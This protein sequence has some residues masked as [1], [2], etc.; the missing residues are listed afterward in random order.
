MA[1][2]FGAQFVLTSLSDLVKKVTD[3]KNRRSLAPSLTQFAK[4]ANIIGR[5]YIEETV[6]HDDIAVPLMGVLNQM[7]V[8]Y[9]LTALHLDTAVAGGR[10]VREIIGK[11][12]SEGYHDAANIILNHFGKDNLDK[13]LSSME[14]SVTKLEEDSQRLVCGRL[15]ELDMYGHVDVS[16]SEITETTDPGSTKLTK[17]NELTYKYDKDGNYGLDSGSRGKKEETTKEKTIT[18]AKTSTGKV[19]QAFKVYMYVQLVPYILETSTAEDFF[20]F[21]FIPGFLR[22]WRQVRTGE[23]KFFRDFLFAKDLIEKQRRAIK[24]DTDGVLGDMML[25]QKSSLFKWL[26]QAIGLRPENHNAASAMCVIS[27]QSFD[28]A[29]AATRVDFA[30]SVTRQTFFYKT[31]TMILVVVDTM[32]GTATMYINGIPVVGKYTFDMINK[33]GTKSRDSFDLKQIMQALNQ[34]MTPKF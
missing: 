10:T 28:A 19:A 20:S 25:R 15:I 34:G 6:A 27:K 13:P 23:I 22:R 14:A 9:I 24:R 18:S 3:P 21:N 2:N 11:V 5:V 30:N 1:V 4:T 8:S 17:E 33:V 12:A 32:Y 31:F 7:Y 16:G 26:L 29:C